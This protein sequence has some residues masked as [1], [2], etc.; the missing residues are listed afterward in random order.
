MG[1]G[2]SDEHGHDLGHHGHDH[3]HIE[4]YESCTNPETCLCEVKRLT[5]AFLFIT[6]AIG[7]QLWFLAVFT[8]SYGA[9]GDVSHSFADNFYYLALI[10]LVLFKR[11]HKGSAT[12]VDLVG[13]CLNTALLFFAAAFIIYRLAFGH[14]TKELEPWAM[15][16]VGAIGLAGNIGQFVALGEINWKGTSNIQGVAQ[17][18]AY[19][20]AN[21]VAVILDA[22]VIKLV[23][24]AIGIFFDQ[25]VAF[26][27][28]M[29]MFWTCWKNW[30]K[31]VEKS[32]ELSEG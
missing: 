8:S 6:T 24:G 16:V 22:G 21:S 29:T 15:A 1:H 7:F 2:H 23:G 30:G 14:Q 11:S 28:A 27:I 17:H 10:P 25:F 19:D 12:R 20:M 13:F 3:S 31:I 18:V 9:E 4:H 5:L 32:V 26:A